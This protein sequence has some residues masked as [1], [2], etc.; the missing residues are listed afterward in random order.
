MKKRLLLFTV[1]LCGLIALCAGALADGYPESAHNYASNTDQSWTYTHPSNADYLEIVF[2]DDTETEASYDVIHITDSEGTEQRFSGSAF[3]NNPVYVKGQSFT[4][5]LTSDDSVEYYGFRIVSIR[6]LTEAQYNAL[7]P[8]Y[9]I[10]NGAITGGSN[11]KDDLVIPSVVN[12]QR[13]TAIGSDAF[14]ENANITSVTIPAGVTEIGES[15][16]CRCSNLRNCSLPQTLTS[17]GRYAFQGCESLETLTIPAGVTEISEWAFA[18]CV[19]M[20]AITFQGREIDLP[21]Y[22][23]YYCTSLRTVTGPIRSIETNAMYL[24]TSLESVTLSD[25]MTALTLDAVP[26]AAVIHIGSGCQVFDRILDWGLFY[27]NDDTGETNV[28]HSSAATVTGKVDDIVAQ[29]ITPGMS[30]YQKALALHN[31]LIFNANYD[32]TYTWF[33]AEGVLLHGAGVCQSYAEAYR[34]MLTRVGIENTLEHGDNHVWNMAKLDGKWYHIDCTWD[35]PNEGGFE[36]WDFFGLTN[37]ALEGVDNHE[38]YDREHI[39]TAYD[40]NFNYRN[41]RLDSY[42]RSVT[43]PIQEALNAGQTSVAFKPV[44]LYGMAYGTVDRTAILV[45][46]DASYS[47]MNQP[48]TME[49]TLNSATHEVTARV[50]GESDDFT[51]PASLISID[52]EA[53]CGIPA[54]AIV[55]PAGVRTI[56]ERAFANC[57]NLVQI[58]IPSSV[59]S[60]ADSAFEGVSGLQI[61]GAAGSAAERFAQTHGYTFI[62]Q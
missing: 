33:S 14:S 44:L 30:D 26:A 24:C 17:I 3:R 60:I 55:V 61:T 35:D 29:V 20:T 43:N 50:K 13:V 6:G 4:I 39:A 10:Q 58:T 8:T 28:V 37:Y 9:T 41:G 59:T 36:R 45:A 7:P 25:S 16:F 62:A 47:Y 18:E 57:P 56:G 51:L 11:L 12:G 34:L 38:C 31:W 48:V 32:H 53:F 46:R 21:S 1:L 27:V 5:R 23:L 40:C 54:A 52:S 22:A 2:S 19:S 42:V 15:A 49:I